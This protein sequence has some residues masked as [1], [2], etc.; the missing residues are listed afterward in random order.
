MAIWN[1]LN[2]KGWLTISKRLTFSYILDWIV[3]FLIAGLGGVFNYVKPYHRPF[4]LLDLSISF[5]I[6]EELF[7]ISLLIVVCGLAPAVIITLIVLICVPGP[8]FNRTQNRAQVL[9]LKIWEWEKGWAGFCLSLAL[10]FFITQGMKNLFGKPRPSLLARCDPDLTDIA[11]HIVGGYGQ[12]ISA[13]WVLVSS[14][15]CRQTDMAILD[16]GF[17]SF[18]SGHSSFSWSA[19]LYLSLFL[20]SK[21]AIT[22][23]FLPN[24]TISQLAG[25]PSSENHHL[26]P[27]TREGR[28]STEDPQDKRFDSRDSHLINHDVPIRNR[29]AAPPNHLIIIAFI[30]IGIAIWITSTRYVEFYHFGFD[31]ISGALI[32]ILSAWFAFRWYHLP[33]RQGQGWAWGARSRNRA[34]GIAVG[35]NNYVG[36][37]GWESKKRRGGDLESTAP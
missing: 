27:L 15:I 14:S 22:I 2:L 32:G 3:I 24:N 25:S 37:E 31:M 35:T 10:A 7:P 28:Y 30:P 11:S 29:A 17:R 36:D 9:R 21:F 5:P 20:C 19:M 18:P 12:D 34:F 26:L 33:V 8:A 1:E 23:P 16:D 13:R 6:E 4:S